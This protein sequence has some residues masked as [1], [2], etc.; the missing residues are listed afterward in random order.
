MLKKYIHPRVGWG[1]VI[2]VL[3][4]HP[5]QAHQHLPPITGYQLL[6]QVNPHPVGHAR[7]PEKI[8]LRTYQNLWQL[9]KEQPRQLRI[10]WYPIWQ[11]SSW[12]IQPYGCHG[13]E[14]YTSRVSMLVRDKINM[15]THLGS[16]VILLGWVLLMN[17]TM[18]RPIDDLETQYEI[19]S[20]LRCQESIM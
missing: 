11:L 17:M 13:E 15:A 7:P 1:L 2:E 10:N 14:M 9:L 16:K 5:P 20:Y 6:G 12:A 3:D 8:E 19:D 18:I 4:F